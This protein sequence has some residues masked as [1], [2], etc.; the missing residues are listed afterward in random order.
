MKKEDVDLSTLARNILDDLQRSEP[1]R[2][3]TTRVE[4]GLHARGDEDLLRI[5]LDNLLGN[6]WKFTG[7]KAK[8]EIEFISAEYDGNAAFSIRDN[9]AGFDMSH[10]DKLFQA[11]QRLHPAKAFP[12]TGIGLAIVHRIVKR[13]GGRIKGEGEVGRG[14]AFTFT[15]S[16]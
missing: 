16:E 4:P 14:A 15:L 1:S 9:G 13:H 5:A 12:G 3:V 10:S 11:F 6:A 8:A 2:Q 7:E